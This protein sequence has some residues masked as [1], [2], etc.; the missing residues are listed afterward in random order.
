MFNI[1][2]FDFRLHR[3]CDQ[4]NVAYKQDHL[5]YVQYFKFFVTNIRHISKIISCIK[6]AV[7][8][9][10]VSA[11]SRWTNSYRA[12]SVSWKLGLQLRRY[13]P[14]DYLARLLSSFSCILFTYVTLID[15]SNWRRC[16]VSGTNIC[17]YI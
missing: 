17:G 16:L 5:L 11:P 8:F 13:F 4:K 9:G 15:T 12:L 6:I 7:R 1:E 3:S 14:Q 10:T 2:N